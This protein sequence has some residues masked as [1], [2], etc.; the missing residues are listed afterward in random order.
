MILSSVFGFAYLEIYPEIEHFYTL[1]Y[2]DVSRKP[3]NLRESSELLV[4]F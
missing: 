3:Q 1:F 4:S 2:R